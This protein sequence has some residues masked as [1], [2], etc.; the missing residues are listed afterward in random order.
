MFKHI[1][2]LCNNYVKYLCNKN[3]L[4]IKN[5]CIVYK[6]D[7]FMSIKSSRTIRFDD[8]IELIELTKNAAAAL[9]SHSLKQPTYTKL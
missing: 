4:I 5:E 1:N 8:S 7:S 2:T 3:V 9:M 6:S